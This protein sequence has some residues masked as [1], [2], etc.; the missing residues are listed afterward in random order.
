MKAKKT[1]TVIVRVEVHIIRDFPIHFAVEDGMH[2]MTDEEL[3][4]KAVKL[5]ERDYV[6]AYFVPKANEIRTF[7]MG[8]QPSRDKRKR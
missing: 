1:K 6:P 8:F 2:E 3:K 5:V 7:D 4:K